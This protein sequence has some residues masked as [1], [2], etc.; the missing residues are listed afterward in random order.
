MVMVRFL[1]TPFKVSMKASEVPSGKSFL[2]GI[3]WILEKY[4]E[5]SAKNAFMSSRLRLSDTP[6]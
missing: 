4:R 6:D 3:G 2:V 5:L 1:I